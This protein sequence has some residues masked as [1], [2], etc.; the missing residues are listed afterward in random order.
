[1]QKF[2][3]FTLVVL[4]TAFQSGALLGQGNLLLKFNPSGDFFV[5]LAADD[6]PW[7]QAP[8]TADEMLPEWKSWQV[9]EN[10]TYGK[11]RGTLT[12]IADL[13]ALHPYFRDK[14]VELIRMCKSKG[15]ELAIVET[16]RTH[17]KQNEYKGMGRKYT[18]SGGGKSKHQYG[19]AVDVVPIVNGKAV[20]DNVVLWRKVGVIG[21]R[22]G[23]RWGG[24]WKHPYDPG[25]FEWTGG[26]SS[27]H[28]ATGMLPP[29]PAD[30]YPCLEE[31]MITLREFWKE[32]ETFQSATSRK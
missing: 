5:E 4:I 7:I 20:W 29:V 32:W 14:V 26:L 12:M 30:K 21:E 19:L 8:F 1:M 31:D 24:R 28:L 6:S 25:H 16:F 15:I 23:L 22:L 17:A 13:N 11:D 10:F 18:N 27:V 2:L 9:V 3:R